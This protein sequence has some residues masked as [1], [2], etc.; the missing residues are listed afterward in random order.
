[1][2][3]KIKHF[4]NIRTFGNVDTTRRSPATSR[5]TPTSFFGQ[6][7][8]VLSRRGRTNLKPY[9]RWVLRLKDLSTSGLAPQN[10][11]VPLEK[12]RASRHSESNM[13]HVYW[14]PLLRTKRRQKKEF[15]FDK[16]EADKGGELIYIGIRWWC[17]W[18]ICRSFIEYDFVMSRFNRQ[19]W[20]YECA[21]FLSW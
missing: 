19:S 10:W 18:H 14:S 3:V 4:W 5:E 20:E 13:E 9:H 11:P 12:S 16:L 8:W 1:M 6:G 2:G 21:D 15:I 17:L 7:Y